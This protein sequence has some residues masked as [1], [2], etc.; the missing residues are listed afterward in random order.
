MTGRETVDPVRVYETII[1]I[2]ARKENVKIKA[3]LINTETGTITEIYSE[4]GKYE[5]VANL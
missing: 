3:T 2:F 5:R 1:R 4:G